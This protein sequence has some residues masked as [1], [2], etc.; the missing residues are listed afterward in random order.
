MK[1]LLTYLFFLC[2]LT[3]HTLALQHF[4]PEG[5]ALMEEKYWYY[6]NWTQGIFIVLISGFF[7]LMWKELWGPKPEEDGS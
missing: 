7:T 5:Y 2:A 4:Y 6:N 1:T 3:L